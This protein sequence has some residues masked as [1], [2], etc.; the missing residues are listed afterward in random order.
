MEAQLETFF[1]KF[2]QKRNPFAIC[3]H[4]KGKGETEACWIMQRR[5]GKSPIAGKASL[6][7][8]GG[9]TTIIIVVDFP[10]RASHVTLN[11]KF[12]ETEAAEIN[13]FFDLLPAFTHA[14]PWH[15]WGRICDDQLLRKIKVRDYNKIPQ[16]PKSLEA[17]K[18]LF[19]NGTFP[20]NPVIYGMSAA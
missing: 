18:A 15:L 4:K 10:W 5:K 19:P 16:F 9:Y 11:P 20:S 17:T 2:I 8:S 6:G 1:K 14:Q 3:E 12:E 13:K 7:T